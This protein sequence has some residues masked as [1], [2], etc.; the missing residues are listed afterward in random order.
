[1]VSEHFIGFHQIKFLETLVI[2]LSPRT[3][4]VRAL[5]LTCVRLALSQ[6]VV[7]DL[8][9]SSSALPHRATT[10]LVLPPLP[11]IEIVMDH[12]LKCFFTIS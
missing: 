12:D 9:L 6:H 7:I 3:S 10:I 5:L 4:R 1:M 2:F 8:S 11:S